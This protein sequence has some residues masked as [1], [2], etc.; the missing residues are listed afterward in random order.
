MRFGTLYFHKRSSPSHPAHALALSRRW[1]PDAGCSHASSTHA[2]HVTLPL[3]SRAG[4]YPPQPTPSGG[5]LAPHPSGQTL[6][7]AMAQA[8][9]AR[10]GVSH[11]LLGHFLRA[12]GGDVSK[13]AS[14]YLAMAD[15][16]VE[17]RA[18]AR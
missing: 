14:L 18:M 4:P 10:P 9:G 5:P 17:L 3:S 15:E 11:E 13:A 16:F 8:V 7:A 2:N 1:M 6:V 12:G